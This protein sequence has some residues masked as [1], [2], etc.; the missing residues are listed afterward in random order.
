[1]S[2]KQASRCNN[3]EDNQTKKKEQNKMSELAAFFKQNKPEKKNEFFPASKDFLDKDG[4][5]IMWELRH[6][7]TITMKRIENECT[8]I[9]GRGKV[10]FDAEL[11]SRKKVAAAVVFPDLR[12]AELVDSYMAGYS[13]EDRTPENLIVLMLDD[14]H[15]FNALLQKINEMDGVKEE[16]E[17]EEGN[18]KIEIAK[19]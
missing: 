11:F 12:N 3:R 9:K 1:M 15:E 2:T 19:N 6:V 10:D 4:N 14:P 17:E 5:P 13:Q 7:P 18:P 16:A 8:T